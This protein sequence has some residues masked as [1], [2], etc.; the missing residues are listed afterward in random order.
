[1]LDK[2]KLDSVR[3]QFIHMVSHNCEIILHLN[4]FVIDGTIHVLTK[5]LHSDTTLTIY[6]FIPQIFVL[7]LKTFKLQQF[8]HLYF[9]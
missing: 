5:D 8:S 7:C 3:V 6:A 1:M 9:Q 2:S 4:A